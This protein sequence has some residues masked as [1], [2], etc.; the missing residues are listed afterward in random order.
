VVESAL[1]PRAKSRVGATGL[2]QFMFSTGKIYGLNV[3]SYVDDR[4]DPVAATE[5]ACLYL[6]SLYKT[7][8]D[9]QLVLAAY[10]SGPG[11]VSK[12][13]R[14][15]NGSTDFWKIRS[16]LPRETAGYLPAFLAT[17]YIFEYAGAHGFKSTGPKIPYI[18]TDT[19][20]V[21]KKIRLQ[22]VAWATNT[23]S[24]EI[25]FLNPSYQL[26]VIPAVK[27]KT[28]T[29][30]L[31]VDAMG[32][33]VANEEAIYAAAEKE[34]GKNQDP[35]PELFEQAEKKR[36]RVRSGDFLSKIAN[37]YKVKVSQ[38]KKWN[39]LRSNTIRVGQ[40]LTVYKNAAP[41]A[42]GKGTPGPI[43]ED[44]PA[45]AGAHNVK[46]RDSLW[47][48]SQKLPRVSIQNLK[49]WNDISGSGLKPGT[50]LKVSKEQH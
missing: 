40:W 49:S 42:S 34:F 13:L 37:H 14:K 7:F 46:K 3:N 29:L 1:D 9:W 28:Y 11:N 38:L 47:G 36:Y 32:I 23:N 31:P 10:N 22:H 21:R 27:G 16:H 30:R 4:N 33:F 26:G 41:I 18:A 48:I 19:V 35:L 25:K 5:A 2:W 15:S 43:T 50:T 17:M 45:D 20:Q 8:G 24:N 12:A 44:I 6:K 39:S